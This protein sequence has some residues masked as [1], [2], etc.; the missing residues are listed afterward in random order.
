MLL[1]L[2]NSKVQSHAGQEQVQVN[3]K[4]PH[5]LIADCFASTMSSYTGL[6]S[7]DSAFDGRGEP[8]VKQRNLATAM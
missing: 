4:T 5:N 3:N 8:R 7:F 2:S 6:G 1:C